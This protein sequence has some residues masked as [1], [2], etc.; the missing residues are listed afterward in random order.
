MFHRAEIL[1]TI[2]IV[3][4]HVLYRIT[5]YALDS[6]RPQQSAIRFSIFNKRTVPVQNHLINMFVV[7]L[8]E[9]FINLTSNR[10]KSLLSLLDYSS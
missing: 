8:V 5:N 4:E 9:E 2:G 3:S 7:L 6:S 10:S 1:C